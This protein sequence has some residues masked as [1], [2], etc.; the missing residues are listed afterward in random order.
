MNTAISL[1]FIKL[2]KGITLYRLLTIGKLIKVTHH[3]KLI[4][5]I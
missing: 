4:E 3:N 5:I 1:K 2:L